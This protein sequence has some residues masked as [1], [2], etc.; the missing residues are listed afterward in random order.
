MKATQLIEELQKMIRLHG[1]LPIATS[2]C[3]GTDQL[4]ELITELYLDSLNRQVFFI[5]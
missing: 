5:H 3:D 1:D 4:S 2:N